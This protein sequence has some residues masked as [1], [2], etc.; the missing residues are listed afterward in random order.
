MST[1]VAAPPEAIREIVVPIEGMTCAGC[2]RSVEEA[3]TGVPGVR[4]AS[5]NLTNMTATATLDREVEPKLLADAVRKAGYGVPTDETIL[6]IA[7]M[8]C[9]SCVGRVEK[10]LLAV[11]GVLAAE[12]SL[13]TE[14]ARVTALAGTERPESL[15]AAVEAAGY[16]ARV[17]EGGAPK[18]KFDFEP[19][20]AI[21]GVAMATPFILDMALGYGFPAR[22]QFIWATLMQVVLGA[23]FYVGAYRAARARTANMDTLVALG[24]T[25][26]WGLSIWLW[27]Q[28]HNEHLYFEAGAVVIAL[29]LLGKWLENRA[30]R[31]AGDAMTALARLQPAIAHVRDGA[32][33]VDRPVAEVRSGQ[34]VLVRPGER[35]PV[36]GLVRSGE[37]DV[38]EALLT[39]ESHS[40]RKAPGDTVTGG[41]IN[42]LGLLEIEV[43]TVGSASRIGRLIRLV[44]RAQASKAPIQRLVDR[45]AAVFVPAVLAIAA[46]SAVGTWIVTGDVTSALVNAVSVLV[47]SCPCALGLATPAAVSV[48]IGA[49]ARAGLLIRDAEALEAARRIDTVV[50]D[51]TGT[52]T[53]GRP[54]IT[55]I[56]PSVD[57]TPELLAL[58]GSAQLGSE[59]PLAH[60]VVERARA[61][62]VALAPPEELRV[63]P[64]LGLEAEVNGRLVHIGSRRLMEE[65]GVSTSAL[66]D[67]SA[68]LERQ[69]KTTIW[70]AA[71]TR[72]VLLGM[73]A[74]TDT[75][76]DSA[77]DAVALLAEKRIAVVMLTGDNRLAAEA[78]AREIGDIRVIAEVMPEGKVEEV[79]RLRKE[80][81]VVAMVGDGV[82]D[83]P[84]LA[85]ADI[86]IAIG[87]A[88]D[89]A[90]EAAKVGLMRPDLRL[91]PALVDLARRGHAK[92]AQNLFWAFVY[93]LV[94]IPLAAI[95]LLTPLVAGAAMA[96][97]SVSV[98]ANALTLRR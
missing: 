43:T 72:P 57:G 86:G 67:E 90:M 36:D 56:R 55:D 34:R 28:G 88:T 26:A 66:A 14:S 63:R 8:T 24:T 59:H 96:F 92:I 77:R 98:V 30:K 31:R 45:I 83:G 93:N 17:P 27:S 76:R 2:V 46:V 53:L 48:A 60:A 37:S 5:A 22:L 10:A 73:M 97:S 80:G 3:L 32:G 4:S 54:T 19:P 35:I 94:G 58:S 84:A 78:I 20:L 74:A 40:V 49:G 51:K 70:I 68:E 87:G 1:A 62:G 39:G 85:A 91:V 16:K 23:R 89:V 52:L 29:V 15:V 13:A 33:T 47:I 21:L 38:D 7:G 6:K 71:G 41:A 12:A 64:G 81:R 50:F 44:E 25:A 65:L 82:N 11:P 9:A 42:G 61:E 69:G 95:G 79:E 75:L 18:A